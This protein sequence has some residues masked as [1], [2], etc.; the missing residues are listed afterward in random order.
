MY[1]PRRLGWCLLGVVAWSAVSA[2][3]SPSDAATW[4]G[5]S[6]TGAAAPGQPSPLAQPQHPSPAT[7]QAKSSAP[8]QGYRLREGAELVD[9]LGSFQ[10]SGDRVVFV[11]RPGNGRFLVLENL[12]LE[13]ITRILTERPQ[14]LPAK[15]TGTVTE[16]R[17][18]NF[19]LIRRASLGGS[20]LLD[21]HPGG[22]MMRSSAS[23]P[24][25]PAGQEALPSSA[26]PQ[27]GRASNPAR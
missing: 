8:P 22:S 9:Q 19:I 23:G 7:D 20:G 6:A 24:A 27:S 16:F 25:T 13:R 3:P 4:A 2:T 15:V 12:N 26:G 21:T 17:G 5:Q 1:L 14:E 18:T 11:V 10:R